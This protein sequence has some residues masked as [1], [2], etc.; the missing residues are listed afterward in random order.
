MALFSEPA[1]S[2]APNRI[3]YMHVKGCRCAAYRVSTT[4]FAR[5][6]GSAYISE[7]QDRQDLECKSS[8]LLWPRSRC[9]T[10]SP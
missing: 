7:L 5:F 1:P 8:L 9:S 10:G 6:W 4:R 3:V 2:K